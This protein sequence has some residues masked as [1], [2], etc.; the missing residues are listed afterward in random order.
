MMLR[1]VWQTIRVLP[2]IGSR[3]PGRDAMQADA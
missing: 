3:S 2:G 1:I